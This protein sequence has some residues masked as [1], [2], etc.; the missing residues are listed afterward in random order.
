[1]LRNHDRSSELAGVGFLPVYRPWGLAWLDFSS[2]CAPGVTRESDVEH[3]PT[4]VDHV[5]GGKMDWSG[6]GQVLTAFMAS[7]LRDS[8]PAQTPL[9]S[10]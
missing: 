3:L 10:S 4:S 1:M 6:D 9:I 2:V 8:D 5:D 7:Y